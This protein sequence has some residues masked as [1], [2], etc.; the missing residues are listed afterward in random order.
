MRVFS[1]R[2]LTLA[3]VG[4]LIYAL[5]WH[6]TPPLEP[7]P[8]WPEGPLVEALPDT[9]HLRLYAKD[10]IAREVVAGRRSLFEAAAL[11]REL[12]RLPP[13]V[14][15]LSRSDGFDRTSVAHTDEERLCRQVIRWVGAVIARDG[16]PERAEAAQRLLADRL[17]AEVQKPETIRL[18][19]PA[20]LEPAGELVERCRGMLSEGRR[21][22]RG[23]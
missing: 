22:R 17:R 8:T 6:P 13:A 10:R 16:F 14:P 7:V 21:G 11:F 2:L 18:P 15:E 20:T 19:D 5:G 1:P 9:V 12:N 4:F 3:P 23:E